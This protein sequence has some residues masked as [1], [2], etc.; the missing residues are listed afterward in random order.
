MRILHVIPALAPRFGGPPKVVVEMCR[1]LARR[2]EQVSI[3][4]TNFDGPRKL[5]VP[6]LKTVHDDSGLDIRYFPVYPHTSYCLSVPLAAALKR[7]V[8]GYDIVHVHSLYRFSTT[9]AAH[10]CRVFGVPYVMRPHGTLDP[11]MFLRHR[12][13]KWLYEALFDRPHLEGAAAVQFTALD[14]MELAKATGFAL[15]GVIVPLGVKPERAAGEADAEEFRARWPE[16]RGK[17][18]ILFLGRVNFKKGLDLLVRA[19]GD[20]CRHRDDVHLFLAGPDDEGYGAR[21]RRWLED[22]GLLGRTTFSG[23]ILGREKAA[24]LAAAHVFVLPSYSENFG[25][26]VVEAL[27]GG[28]PTII[29]NKVNIWREVAQA[30]AGIVVNCDV[31]ELKQAL[32]EVLEES[33]AAAADERGWAEARERELQLARGGRQADGSLPRHRNP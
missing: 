1:E 5:D 18:V 19:F 32:L 9:A 15:N 14:E 6:L 7:D 29:S 22:L 13:R 16:T 25:V 4:T 23:M 8:P 33:S 11:F 26:A 30:G 27:A 28:L 3:Y 17:K 20:V 21:V 31:A 12:P 24:A 2:G 10:Y